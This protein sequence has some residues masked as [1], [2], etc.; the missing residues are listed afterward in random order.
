MT[1]KVPVRL[2]IIPVDY[3]VDFKSKPSLILELVGSRCG[4]KRHLLDEISS[5]PIQLGH[6]QTSTK[7][8][9]HF[10]M[11]RFQSALLRHLIFFTDIIITTWQK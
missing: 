2:V 11:S 9:S 5:I 6:K 4:I 7:N 10:V 3:A 8:C 1:R